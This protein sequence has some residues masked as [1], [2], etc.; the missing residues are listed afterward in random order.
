M[1]FLFRGRDHG[2][3]PV[4]L[5]KGGLGGANVRLARALSGPDATRA[6]TQDCRL[7]SRTIEACALAMH[8]T[9]SYACPHFMFRL[10]H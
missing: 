10:F 2:M 6:Y 5:T 9:V 4:Y 3:V 7:Q 8:E 1:I